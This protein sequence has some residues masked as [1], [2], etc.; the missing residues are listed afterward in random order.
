MNDEPLVSIIVP[1]YNAAEYLPRL[2]ESVLDQ[3]YK[4][5][6]LILVNDGSTDETKSI[7][8]HYTDNNQSLKFIEIN[9]ENG[10]QAS[11]INEGLKRVS[12][13]YLMWVDADDILDPNNVSSKINFF[14]T[15]S[16]I[17]FV[18]CGAKT[19]DENDRVLGYYHPTNRDEHTFFIS[20]IKEKHIF[21]P[22]GIYMVEFDAFREIFPSLH[23]EESRLGQNWQLLL[24]L[25]YHLKCGIIDD[26]AFTYVIHNNSHSRQKT[27]LD[28]WTQFYIHSDELLHHIVID[29][30]IVEEQEIIK[31]IDTK[32]QNLLLKACI[33]FGN[34]S[35]F[36]NYYNGILKPTYSQKM[37]YL[38]TR[39]PGSL[40]LIKKYFMR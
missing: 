8:S 24:P 10:G 36:D 29:M 28:Q 38:I 14:R 31:L 32:Y 23:I 5:I 6:E 26:I 20:L 4:N 11:A 9:K 27:T 16:Q 34:K 15:H 39:V 13:E 1:C 30:N 22:P 3:T 2:I 25:A 40:F 21:F 7:I 12:G 33:K 19:I 35:A 37:Y 18:Q 17:K